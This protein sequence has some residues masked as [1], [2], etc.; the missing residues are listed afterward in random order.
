MG[1]VSY[2]HCLPALSS[3]KPCWVILANPGCTQSLIPG[4]I[5]KS[6]PAKICGPMRPVSAVR[7]ENAFANTP[8]AVE[9][10]IDDFLRE[11]KI[12]LAC[13]W[14]RW[15]RQS[16]RLG[17]LPGHSKRCHIA[18]QTCLMATVQAGRLHF[19]TSASS[20][21]TSETSAALFHGSR[22]SASLQDL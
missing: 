2:S 11:H 9:P 3:A 19:C 15:R 5:I 14:W 7:C 10:S 17:L 8:S 6:F 18:V 21:R 16:L 20:S 22:R 4:P 13:R 12:K 1:P